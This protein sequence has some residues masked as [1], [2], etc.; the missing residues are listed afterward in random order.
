[1]ANKE[2]Q[3][4]KTAPKDGSEF[5]TCNLNQGK[6]LELVSWNRLYGYWQSK[7]KAISMQATHWLMIPEFKKDDTKRG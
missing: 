7:G 5:L 4:I 1:M 6:V 2:W 3:D